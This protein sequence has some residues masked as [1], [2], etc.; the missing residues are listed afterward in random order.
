MA[1]C[2]A[3]LS[4][5]T[6]QLQRLAVQT[7]TSKTVHWRHHGIGL[8]QAYL[9]PSHR[10]HVW[11]EDLLI[12]G[13]TESGAMHDHRFDLHSTVLAG[14]LHNNLIS[15][16]DDGGSPLDMW[17]IPRA[18]KGTTEE[19]RRVGGV[20]AHI[21]PLQILTPGHTHSIERGEFHWARP[22]SGSVGVTSV[23]AMDKRDTSARLLCPSG[24]PPVH[25][26]DFESDDRTIERV[27]RQAIAS[28]R[29]ALAR[30][31]GAS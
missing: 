21:M 11:S 20:R 27:R 29:S 8:I 19:M 17:E 5:Q 3:H 16:D 30:G 10:L 22:V 4:E 12:P 2:D 23:I 31:D 28:L 1:T 25:A 7:L 18:S 6:R 24:K 13:M 14:S 9:S 26:F 15:L